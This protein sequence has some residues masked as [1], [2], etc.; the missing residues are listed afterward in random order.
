MMRPESVPALTP[1]VRMIVDTR[2]S[3]RTRPDA[4]SRKCA[5]NVASR[6]A[7]AADMT[8]EA[9]AHMAA[10]TPARMAA[11]AASAVTASAVPAS[12]PA[13]VTTA[14]RERVGRYRGGSNCDGHDQNNYFA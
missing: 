9:P 13:T 6:K 5:A 7:A 2:E 14:A 4:R 12:A 8:A 3:V 10:E 1:K 11:S